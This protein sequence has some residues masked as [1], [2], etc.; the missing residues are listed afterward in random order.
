MVVV[1]ILIRSVLASTKHSLSETI[2][3]Q[4]IHGIIL[5]DFWCN[6]GLKLVFAAT[7]TW[8]VMSFVSSLL[9]LKWL[10]VPLINAHS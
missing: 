10:H 6:I 8:L 4:A 2:F 5:K 7:F 3:L 1:S 9:A